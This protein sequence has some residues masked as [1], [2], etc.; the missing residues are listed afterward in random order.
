MEKMH[1]QDYGIANLIPKKSY[2]Y[3]L[4]LAEW[5]STNIKANCCFLYNTHNFTL[6]CMNYEIANRSFSTLDIFKEQ[7]KTAT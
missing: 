5:C 6:L 1:V 4:I 2:I 3:Y 7:H